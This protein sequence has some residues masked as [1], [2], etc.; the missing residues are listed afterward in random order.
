M[1][2]SYL[3]RLILLVVL[4]LYTPSSF[5]VQA[6]LDQERVYNQEI[7]EA[8]KKTSFLEKVQALQEIATDRAEFEASGI[9]QYTKNNQQA[10]FNALK[11]IA[12]EQ[13]GND[14]AALTSLKTLLENA[15]SSTS[16]L[17]RDAHKLYI[18]NQLLP[19]LAAVPSSAVKPAVTQPAPTQAGQ[20]AA[21][22]VAPQQQLANNPHFSVAF[23]QSALGEK[24]NAIQKVKN[25]EALLTLAEGFTF[26]PDVQN[27]F[28]QAIVTISQDRTLSEEAK[29]QLKNAL[30][31]ATTTTLLSPAQQKHVSNRLLGTIRVHK[32]RS[33]IKKH[34]D[35]RR[36]KRVHKKQTQRQ[37]EAE[38]KIAASITKALQQTSP[39]EQMK[40]L[41][42]IIR[43]ATK[44]RFTP[45]TQDAFGNALVMLFNNRATYKTADLM[46]LK[47]LLIRSQKTPLLS[48]AQQ[49]YVTEQMLKQLH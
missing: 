30:T 43:K 23:I 44:L 19:K 20:L 11:K 9:A 5:A 16:S 25:L 45:Q 46:E 24:Q 39:R 27:A 33:A 31:R 8:L 6:T 7:A 34:R 41:A 49:K 40:K 26:G 32:K 17:L 2:K 42:N 13:A 14:T 4:S 38:Q 28:A 21:A 47:K 48:P 37:L 29:E 15:H 3:G 12:S 10:F 1:K 35:K 22:T 18:Q 36:K